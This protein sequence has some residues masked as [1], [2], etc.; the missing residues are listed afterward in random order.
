MSVVAHGPL[1]V[2]LLFFF[3][4]IFYFLIQ[5]LAS[6]RVNFSLWLSLKYIRNPDHIYRLATEL[7][8]NQKIIYIFLSLGQ[9]YPRPWVQITAGTYIFFLLF[10]SSFLF[11]IIIITIIIVVV[12]I[13]GKLQVSLCDR[14]LSVVRLSGR[15]SVSFSH[16]QQRPLNHWIDWLQT[17]KE[18]SGWLVDQK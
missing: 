13:F 15:P 12:I 11:I 16:F 10:F 6:L 2:Y 8:N 7:N 9:G 17:L 3:S 1:V 18:A 4:F 14:L 5:C